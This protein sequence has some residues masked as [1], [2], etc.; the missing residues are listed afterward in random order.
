MPYRT[1]GIQAVADDA[2]PKLGGDL[3]VNGHKITSAENG[4][5]QLAP[6]GTGAIVALPGGNARGECAVDLGRVRAV[7]TDVASG[8]YATIGGGRANTVSG[9]NS[10]VAGG[11]ENDATGASCGVGGGRGAKAQANYAWAMGFSLSAQASYAR[12]TGRQAIARLEG[13]DAWSGVGSSY[14]V[15]RSWFQQHGEVTYNGGT[16]QEITSPEKL[17]LESGYTYF[18]RTRVL[19]SCDPSNNLAVA[20]TYETLVAND[21]GSIVVFDGPTQICSMGSGANINVNVD[22]YDDEA[23]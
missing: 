3:D 7:D 9:I 4:D 11:Y 20:A 1:V 6:H 16:P 14:G 15:Q 5:V 19:V 17:T 22:T 21:G 23:L 18:I 8:D 13:E 2:S 10:V 12:A